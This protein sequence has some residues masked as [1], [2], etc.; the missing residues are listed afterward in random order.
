MPKLILFFWETLKLKV[1]SMKICVQEQSECPLD[2]IN[3]LQAL[4]LPEDF[5]NYCC[6]MIGNP[7]IMDLVFSW[8]MVIQTRH[9]SFTVMPNLGWWKSS[10]TTFSPFGWPG[11][12]LSTKT[13]NWCV[14]SWLWFG[15]FDRATS[16]S[17][18]GL[19]PSTFISVIAR[20]LMLFLKALILPVGYFVY[21]V[22]AA[23]SALLLS[24]LTYFQDYEDDQT[25]EES[26]Q[27][28]SPPQLHR[29]SAMRF[30]QTLHLLV[31][32]S[33]LLSKMMLKGMRKLL[34]LRI[35]HMNHFSKKHTML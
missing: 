23:S 18:I 24:D 35:H 1:A 17:A 4:S 25:L 21:S 30:A 28:D 13:L 19:D 14:D 33:V 6:S 27:Q 9:F 32:I 10:Q 22:D 15:L 11:C 34:L 5:R 29:Q 8:W 16:S 20:A 26:L 2:I 12:H 7:S 3:K 31:M